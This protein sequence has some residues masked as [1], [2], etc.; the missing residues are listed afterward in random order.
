M[1]LDW[2]Q[3]LGPILVWPVVVLIAIL[4]FYKPLCELLARFTDEH[5][6]KLKIGTEGLELTRTVQEVEK[7]VDNQGKE[8]AWIKTLVRLVLSDSERWNLEQF[9]RDGPFIAKIERGDG[10]EWEL[11]HLLSLKLIDRLKDRGMRTLYEASGDRNVKDHLI[12]TSRGREYLKLCKETTE[13]A[14]SPRSGAS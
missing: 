10:F 11:R 1:M 3:T 7:K 13:E 12:I 8:I 4:V 9:A 2:V 5:I 6:Q 14:P